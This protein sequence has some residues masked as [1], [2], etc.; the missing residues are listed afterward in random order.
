MRSVLSPAHFAN[1]KESK[2]HIEKLDGGKN[3]QSE[4]SSYESGKVIVN[5]FQ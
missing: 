4:N 3:G 2:T 1:E 5:E